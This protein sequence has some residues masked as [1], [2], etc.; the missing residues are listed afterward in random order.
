MPE[1][2]YQLQDGQFR[3]VSGLAASAAPRLPWT[4]QGRVADLAL[5]GNTLY[6]AVNGAG[7]ASL[8][9]GGA[10]SFRYVRDPALFGHRTVTALV[11]R[12]GGLTAHLYFNSML[13]TVEAA[14]L[15]VKG[16]SLVSYHPGA[17]SFSPLVPPFQRRHQGWE[18]VGFL[19]VAADDFLFEWKRSGVKDTRFAYTRLALPEGREAP[20]T[21]AAYLGAFSLPSGSAVALT[22]SHSALFSFCRQEIGD[23]SRDTA[24]HYVLRSRADPVKRVFRSGEGVSHLITVPVWE[25][26]NACIALLPGGRLLRA[27]ADGSRGVTTLP[28]LP[29]GFRYTDVVRLGQRLVLPWEEDSFTEVGAAGLLLYPLD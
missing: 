26:D 4:V 28:A 15:P 7:L 19:P 9:A 6:I 23:V 24:V 17:S 8:D 27:A 5:L 10:V 25:E 22:P 12:D 29:A 1:A 11:P 14:E 18:A 13:N 20:I 3:K 21:R 2:W 16:V